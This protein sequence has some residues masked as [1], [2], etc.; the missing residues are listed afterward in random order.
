MAEEEQHNERTLPASQRRRDEARAKGNVAK[1]RDLISAAT[2]LG[3]ALLVSSLWEASVTRFI[4]IASL[5][6]S[7]ALPAPTTSENLQNVMLVTMSETLWI[8]VPVIGFFCVISV[9]ASMGQYGFLWTGE[10]LTPNW[11]R[12]NPF[13]GF[14]RIFSL[15]SLFE[16]LKT[17]MKLLVI[18]FVIYKVTEKEIPALLVSIQQAPNM[19]LSDVARM[20]TRLLFLS[21]LVVVFIGALDYGFQWWEREKKLRMTPQELKEELRQTEG[22]PLIKARIHS[23]QRQMARRRMMA[24][25]PKAAVVITNPTHLAIA[26]SYDASKMSAPRVVAKG[27]GFMAQKIREVAAAHGVPLVENKPLAQSIF[28][29]VSLGG[30]IPSSLYRA[31]AEILIYIYKLRG[32]GEAAGVRR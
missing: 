25:V 14:S 18:G 23:I 8:I 32:D 22:N 20:I 3:A 27:A 28:K 6:W 21:G 7:L 10:G 29:M 17:I 13:T 15:N 16:F 30:E 19:I 31:V 1:S 11:S 26:L 2:I 4:K 24:D 9:A 12:V 5:N